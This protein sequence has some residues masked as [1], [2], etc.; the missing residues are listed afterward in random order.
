MKSL[1]IEIPDIIT[2]VSEYVPEIITFIEGLV[3]NGFAYVANNS[4]YF[5]TESYV[6]AGFEY[7][8]LEPWSIKE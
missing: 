6:N 2:R 5:D 4:V 7:G 8:K 3:S 1:N